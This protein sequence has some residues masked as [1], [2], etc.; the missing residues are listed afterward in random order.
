MLN[1]SLLRKELVK[2]ALGTTPNR[3]PDKAM[4]NVLGGKS[5]SASCNPGQ[6]ACCW[7]GSN[8]IPCLVNHCGCWNTKEDFYNTSC[9]K[10]AIGITTVCVI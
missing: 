3:M 4:K 10:N 5:D 8:V 9:V 6:A 7:Y 2:I 1:Q